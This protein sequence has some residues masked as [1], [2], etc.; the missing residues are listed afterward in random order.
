MISLP[1]YVWYH[2]EYTFDILSTIF[3][4]SYPLCMTTQHC[5]LFTPH[6]AYV[7]HNLP[8]R[9]C[10]IHSITPSHNIYDFT[11]TSDMTSHPR[12]RHRTNCIFVITTSP[13]I[14]HP[15]L[16]DITPTICM[17]SYALYITSYPL[18]LS[19]HYCT[20]TAQ[21][22]HIKPHPVCS[23]KYTLSMWHHSQ[24]SV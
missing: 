2:I 13:L 11:S 3:M 15:H 9:R 4:T 19:S 7:W 8:Y 16:Y 20:M 10:H 22:W 5:E 12:V 14:S 1:P 23:S 21:P 6:S 17:T 18:L 24:Y